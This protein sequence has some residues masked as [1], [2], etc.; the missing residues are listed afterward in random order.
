M[1][2]R[3][4]SVNRS[5]RWASQAIALLAFA[6]AVVL[7]M[8]WL[9]G[10]FSPKV[11]L[12]TAAEHADSPPIQGQLAAA[13]VIRLPLTESAVG[14]IRAVHETSIGSKLLARVVQV[15]LKAGEQVN[16][17]DVLVRLD[18]TDLQA[19]LQQAKAAVVSMQAAHAQAVSDEKRLRVAHLVRRGRAGNTTKPS[20]PCGPPK[21]HSARRKKR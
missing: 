2:I 16:K 5:V 7:L 8:L 19:K 9:A 6:A 3:R 12:D 20:R 17:G 13:R 14:T 11:P 1:T 10:K 15:N 21:R 4:N 18:E